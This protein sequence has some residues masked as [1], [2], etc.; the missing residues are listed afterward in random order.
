MIQ[1]VS[2]FNQDIAQKLQD[3]PTEILKWVTQV[4]LSPT[5]LARAAFCEK[6]LRK[7]MELGTEQYVIL[8]AGLD[9][10]C[11]R[12]LQFKYSLENYVR[13]SNYTGI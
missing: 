12:H 8:G 4:Q 13:P 1:A 10:F 11:F 9:T 6:V 7:E 3:H 5:P 2:F